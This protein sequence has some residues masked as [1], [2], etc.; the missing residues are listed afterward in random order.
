MSPAMIY[1]FQQQSFVKKRHMSYQS[2]HAKP[3]GTAFTMQQKAINLHK[4]RYIKID[5]YS[6]SGQVPARM[7]M[8]V[9]PRLRSSFSTLYI[10]TISRQLCLSLRSCSRVGC[11]AKIPTGCFYFAIV[12]K[13]LSHI[14]QEL[15]LTARHCKLVDCA[16]AMI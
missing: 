2:C 5:Y 3:D 10:W 11:L 12:E 13:I 14:I 6:S 9:L 4:S 8:T 1:L 16:K 15:I 7:T